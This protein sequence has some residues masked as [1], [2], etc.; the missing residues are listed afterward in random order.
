MELRRRE[1]EETYPLKAG[2]VFGRLSGNDVS[3]QDGSISRKHAQVEEVDG[4][5]ELVDL[6][7]SNGIFVNGQRKQR[8]ALRNG[9]LVTLGAVAFDVVGKAASP[10]ASAPS[11]TSAAADEIESAASPSASS[12]RSSSD[13]RQAS[14]MEETERSRA[15]L[16]REVTGDGRSR[17]LGDLGQQ[18][19]G[20]QVLAG[21]LGLAVLY[22]VVVGIRFLSASL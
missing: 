1:T 6:G 17:G 20:I 15:R 19:L 22:G 5:M 16:R 11:R 4:V 12:R 10:Q 13:Q 2:M 21:L 14:S 18:P 7:S 3:I 8:F 9:D